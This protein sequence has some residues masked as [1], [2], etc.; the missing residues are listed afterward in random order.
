[1]AD[2]TLSRRPVR[3]LYPQSYP[4]FEKPNFSILNSGLVICAENPVK[5]YPL[6]WAWR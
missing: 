5:K 4:Q 1:M 2:F 3:V 6:T